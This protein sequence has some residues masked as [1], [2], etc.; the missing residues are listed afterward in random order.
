MSTNQ[1]KKNSPGVVCCVVVILGISN[2][3]QST[4]CEVFRSCGVT[5]CKNKLLLVRLMKLSINYFKKSRYHMT[6]I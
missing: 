4:V 3:E 5:C 1:N 2:G 6:I